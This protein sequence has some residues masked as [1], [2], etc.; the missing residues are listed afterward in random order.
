MVAALLG[1]IVL[2]LGATYV[3][4]IAASSFQQGF[5][6]NVTFTRKDF[7]PYSERRRCVATEIDFQTASKD[8]HID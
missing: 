1:V 6:E 2:F 8:I 5:Q 4:G 7:V 3:G